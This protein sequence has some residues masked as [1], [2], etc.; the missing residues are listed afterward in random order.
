MP[1][2]LDTAAA[3]AGKPRGNR[4]DFGIRVTSRSPQREADWAGI[5]RIPAGK[6]K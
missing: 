5:G 2:T 1:V 6:P 3:Q 4:W